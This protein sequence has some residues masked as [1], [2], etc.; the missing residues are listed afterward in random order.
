MKLNWFNAGARIWRIGRLNV[1]FWNLFNRR[2]TDG[3]F[4][5]IGILQVNERHLLYIGFDKISALWIKP[6]GA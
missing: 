3:H 6:K 2:S 5:G 1:R 4:W